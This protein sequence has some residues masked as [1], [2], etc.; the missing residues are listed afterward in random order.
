MNSKSTYPQTHYPPAAYPKSRSGRTLALLM[1][2][3]QKLEIG[4]RIKQLR[5]DSAETNRSIA[6]YTGKSTEAVRNWIQGKGILY[7]NAEKVAELFE[8]DIDWLWRGREKEDTPDPFGGAVL[9]AEDVERLK[10]IEEKL[11]RL[12]EER[13]E[14]E[15]GAPLPKTPPPLPKS[16]PKTQDGGEARSRPARRRRA[17]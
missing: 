1:N 13:D 9:S 7:D 17:S 3:Q 5:D 8:V 2:Q 14:D 10:R 4:Q 16:P 15:G 11:D 6:A 12:L